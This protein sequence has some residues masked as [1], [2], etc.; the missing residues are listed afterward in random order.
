M[1]LSILG[2]STC[3]HPPLLASERA[4]STVREKEGS[5]LVSVR[6]QEGRQRL[7]TRHARQHVRH[8]RFRAPVRS[9]RSHFSM[10]SCSTERS[11]LPR[12]LSPKRFYAM[13]TVS[14]IQAP[15]S[16][17]R[18]HQT[19]AVMFWY[20]A[21]EARDGK[22]APVDPHDS[23]APLLYGR[24]G[25]PTSVERWPGLKSILALCRRVD[26]TPLRMAKSAVYKVDRCRVSTQRQDR[27]REPAWRY[28]CNAPNLV[29]LARLHRYETLLSLQKPPLLELQPRPRFKHE[30][31]GKVRGAYK[32]A[33][34]CTLR[35]ACAVCAT[36]TERCRLY[37]SRMLHAV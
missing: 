25:T 5:T 9:T 29:G 8:C 33:F 21:T 24:R 30:L 26:S 4:C 19:R 12:A 2:L 10:L 32:R 37:A 22:G 7:P 16:R 18:T 27:L 13:Q 3:T 14:G 1:E 20:A 15:R 31:C 34:V 11:A 28:G 35:V 36:A 6:L 17:R 23:T